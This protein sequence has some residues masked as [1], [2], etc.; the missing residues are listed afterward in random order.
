[1][2]P[3]M[4][5]SIW[6]VAFTFLFLCSC[7]RNHTHDEQAAETGLEPLAYTLYSE[8]TELFVE[9]KPL[10]VGAESRFATH[11]TILGNLFKPLANGLITITL[12]VQ[13]KSQQVI[14]PAS[15][16]PGLFKG[17]LTPKTAGQGKLIFNIQSPSGNDEIIIENITVYPNASIAAEQLHPEDGPAE[18]SFLKEQAWKTDFANTIVNKK[19]LSGV[20][21]TSGQ[22]LSAPGDEFPLVAN[23]SGVI[24]FTGNLTV[25][26]LFIKQGAKL[27]S[28]SGGDLTQNNVDA[29]YM[30][31]KTN[32][33]QATADFKRAELLAVDK[34]ISAKEMLQA[35]TNYVNA[36]SVYN[37]VSKNY[38]SGKGLYIAA[39]AD[40]Y[41]RNITV[42]DGSFIQA[43]T[44]LATISKNKKLHLVG[45]VS[46]KYFDK[47]PTVT[48]AKFKMSGGENIYN[49]N[50]LN[51]RI[52]SFGK[53]LSAA[54]PYIP[55]TFE[56]DNPGDI[57]PGVIVEVFMT[58]ANSENTLALPVTSLIEEQG[59]F[60]V[61]VQSSGEGFQKREVK[62]GAT[63]GEFIQI[64]S[65][66]TEGERVVN[67]GAYQIKLASAS[68]T[69]PAHGHEH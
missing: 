30:Q 60:Y 45:N 43:G 42:S 63:D 50:E 57:L 27:F 17:Q 21:K 68:G 53:S 44:T 10:V 29:A 12:E 47:L 14:A 38:Q 8:K 40:G 25:N 23:A 36:R 1:M 54:S 62:T 56:I 37:T 9:F 67:K 15:S 39:P 18:I 3:V 2:F 34:I 52:I 59:V 64:L 4:N 22:I 24:R 33:D 48:G 35:K 51:G 28:I 32:Y 6:A 19:Q 65:G 20:I 41:I 16:S 55:V 58:M 46:Q 13:G 5:K 66:V 26:G 49:T 69:L 31:A 61:F 7:A 11:L